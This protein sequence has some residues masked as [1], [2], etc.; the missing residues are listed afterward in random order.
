MIKMVFDKKNEAIKAN[1]IINKNMGY[2]NKSKKHSNVREIINPNHILYKKFFIH[3]PEGDNFH[4]NKWMENVSNDYELYEFN[5]SW[6]LTESL[7][8]EGK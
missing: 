8:K 4:H 1:N 3:Y 5:D 6:L 2:E 7:R